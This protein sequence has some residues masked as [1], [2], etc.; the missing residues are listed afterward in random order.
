M[1]GAN[2]TCTAANVELVAASQIRS[3]HLTDESIRYCMSGLIVA[4]G[5]SMFMMVERGRGTWPRRYECTVWYSVRI[6][7]QF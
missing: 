7:V 6:T 2:G 4:A 5:D 1:L 3:S